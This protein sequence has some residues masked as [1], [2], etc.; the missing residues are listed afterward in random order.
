[1]LQLGVSGEKFF[2]PP[3]L[4]AVSP[5]AGSG[6]APSAGRNTQPFPFQLS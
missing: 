3:I 6:K 5:W 4:Q 2:S 1:M